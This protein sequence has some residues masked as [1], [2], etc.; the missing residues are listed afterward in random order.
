MAWRPEAVASPRLIVV[1]SLSTADTMMLM[2]LCDNI[3]IVG[4]CAMNNGGCS[5]F[6]WT[7]SST[8]RA[9]D[10]AVGFFLASD[11]TTCI[12]RKSYVSIGLL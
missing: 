1:T 10:C 9:C 7:L 8:S 12:S 6:C 4:P 3:F 2:I 11:G 5:H